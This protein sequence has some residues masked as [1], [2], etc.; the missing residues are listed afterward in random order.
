MEKKITWNKQQEEALKNIEAQL[1]NGNALAYTL[2]GYAG[3]GKTTLAGEIA[4]AADKKDWSVI[5]IAPTNKAAEVLRK[6]GNCARTVHKLVYCVDKYGNK[7]KAWPLA[8]GCRNEN[9]G[10]IIC[11]EASMLSDVLLNDLEE[12]A[13][14]MGYKIL[15]MGDPFQLPPVGAYTRTVFDN[16]HKSVLTQVMRQ[17]EGSSI[18]DWATALRQKKTAFS[19][20]VTSGDVSVEDKAT[21]WNDYLANLKAGKDITMV[22]W[23]NEARVRFNLGVRKALG[24]DGKTLQKGEPIMGISNGMFLHNG[25]TQNVPENIELVGNYQLFV[26][27]P[28]RDKALAVIAEFYQY[29]EDGYTRKIILVPDFQGASIAPQ[30][31]RGIKYW[32]DKDAPEF[33]RKF[34]ARYGKKL[35]LASDV[36]I[37]TYGYAITAHKSQ[38]S[39]WEEVYITGTSK[40]FGEQLTNARWLYTAVT[41]AE[42]KVHIL[43]GECAKLDWKDMIA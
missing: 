40:L 3:T 10:L 35:G 37:C 12:Y 8:V 2:M 43:D 22:T 7:E 4:N 30:K 32:L 33:L 14:H 13:M 15:Y 27:I 11:D 16:E 42:N 29:E 41:R 5:F 25:E 17:G 20:A 26:D 28:N 9:G 21:L 24:Y 1:I 19:P 39:Q 18:L 31:L 38:G 36:T 34:V 23:K 6:K